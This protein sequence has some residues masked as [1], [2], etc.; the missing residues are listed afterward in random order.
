MKT[1]VITGMLTRVESNVADRWASIQDSVDRVLSQPVSCLV[2]DAPRVAVEVAE[3]WDLPEGDRVALREW[4]L[5]RVPLF[6]PRHACTFPTLLPNRAGKHERRLV[7]DGQQLYD[8]GYWGTNPSSCVAGVV[9]GE[10]RVL[11]LLPAA[12]TVD[13]LPEVLRPYNRG[14]HKPAVSF[15]SS[16]VTQY[17]ET[18][19]RRHAV[20]QIEEPEFL[21]GEAEYLHYHDRLYSLVELVVD[22]VG[23]ID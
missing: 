1:S 20:L 15:F 3:R 12:I 5:P 22:A 7:K 8:L 21:A 11:C 14:L 9:P 19:W 4:G 23:H 6:T 10:G 16:S 2:A 17:V 18:A 13:D